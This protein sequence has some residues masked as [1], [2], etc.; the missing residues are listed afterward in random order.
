[1]ITLGVALTVIC[2]TH[3]GNAE[4]VRKAFS[5]SPYLNAAMIT[6]K[7][8]GLNHYVGDGGTSFGAFQLHRGGMGSEFEHDTGLNLANPSTRPAQYAYVRRYVERHGG[9]S[10]NVWHGLRH[11]RVA[12][13][14]C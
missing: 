4:L 2:L 8:E 5:G 11:V 7:S 9:F 14:Q 10:S 6:A 3:G 12:Q 13:A 1:M